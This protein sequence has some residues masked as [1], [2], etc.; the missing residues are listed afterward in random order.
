MAPLTRPWGP[1]PALPPACPST[2][3]RPDSIPSPTAVAQLPST[4]TSGPSII[5][6]Q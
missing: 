3:I 5:P 4:T 6:A 2:R 1:A